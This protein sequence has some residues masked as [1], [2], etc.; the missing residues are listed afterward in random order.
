[1]LVP[2]APT[3]NWTLPR[4]SKLIRFYIWFYVKA[5]FGLD[6][7]DRRE[8]EITRSLSTLTFCRLFWAVVCAPFLTLL[9]IVLLPLIALIATIVWI[10]G[11]VK[12]RRANVS[13]QERR[14]VAAAERVTKGPNIFQ[15]VLTAVGNFF[16][17]IAAFFQNH[18]KVGQFLGGVGTVLMWTIFVVIP[19]AVIGFVTY[20]IVAHLNG[21]ITGLIWG[22]VVA[23]GLIAATILGLAIAGLLLKTP[24]GTWLADGLAAVGIHVW[25]FLCWIGRGFR[26]TGR[27]F[28]AGHHA[29]KYRTCPRVVVD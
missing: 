20:E 23:S 25:T 3:H 10:V 29:V 4:Q 1:M 22:G 2:D 26:G 7:D 19:L 18:P 16:D 14:V 28:A 8:G 13:R 15:R 9:V 11:K 17:H 6:F 12:D 21:M 24:F 5:P 27:F